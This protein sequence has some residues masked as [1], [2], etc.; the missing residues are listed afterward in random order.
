MNIWPSIRVAATGGRVRSR[1][2]FAMAGGPTSPAMRAAAIPSAWWPT[3]RTAAR[4]TPL[5]NS[6][7]CS[8]RI[9]ERAA[10]AD[11]GND[12][13]APLSEEE[14]K[15]GGGKRKEDDAD[16]GEIVTPIPSDF[17]PQLRH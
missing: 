11:A 9:R 8:A 1:S 15:K 17:Q 10:M 7:A 14:R 2:T 12:P 3:S 5:R 16:E 4:L 6:P 13:F